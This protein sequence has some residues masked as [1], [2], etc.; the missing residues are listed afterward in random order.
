MAK[1]DYYSVLGVGR[2]ASPDEL[3]KAFRKLAMKFHP[4]KN[5][6]DR[7]AE[8]RFKEVNEAYDVLSDPQK[9]Q[10]YDQFG[11]SAFQ[12]GGPGAGQG[13]FRGN[14][15]GFSGGPGGFQGFDPRQ[16]ENFQDMFSDFFGDF[17]AGGAAPGRKGGFRQ[18]S[19]GADLR[20]TMSI[21]LEEA[22]TGCEKRINFV[23]HRG[24]K[25]DH[26]KLSITVPA[27]VKPGQRLK[28]RGEGDNSPGGGKA[29]DLYV[30]VN[31]QEHPLFRRKD[32]DVLLELPLS[33]V[34]ALLGTQVEV[35]TLT[36]KAMLNVPP[37]T[38]P[39]QVFRLK[40]K[41]FPDIGGYAPGDMLIKVIV[42]IPSSITAE[43]KELLEKL[44]KSS[45][46][47]PLVTEF[48]DKMK[49]LLQQRS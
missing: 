18:D 45:N 8:E 6:G 3:K 34:D 7:T 22:A 12:A 25:E 41:G 43:E 31:F 49:R 21:T 29:G 15:E 26:A 13:P 10:M 40:G 30:I 44:R 38:H 46:S 48:R 4:D 16:G 32:N 33:F 28:L 42:D 19:R 23:R 5:P 35:P 36:G 11:H 27:G 24:G 37:N 1:K 47:S 20:Y 14:F 9:K 39:G 2:Q 17:F